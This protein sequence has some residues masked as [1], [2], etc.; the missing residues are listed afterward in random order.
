MLFGPGGVLWLLRH[1]LRLSW[2]G[3]WSATKSRGY[4]R[5][6]LYISLAAFLGFGGYWIARVLSYV[7][8]TPSPL[9]LGILGGVF[10]ILLTLMVSQALMLITEALYTRGDLDLLLASPLPP[11][12]VLIV[13]MAAI[14]LNVATLYLILLFA[15]FIWL[16]FFNGWRWMAFAPSVLALAL[17]ATAVGLAIAR[18]LFI[19]IGARATRVTA[20]VLAALI[21]AA[22]FLGSQVPNFSGGR[23][24][25][26]IIY[27]AVLD[28]L[29][30]IFGDRGSVLSLPGRSALGDPIA[31]LLWLGGAFAIYVIAVW[32]FSRRFA[33]SAA[34]IAA[35]GSRKRRDQ[36]TYGTQGGVTQSLLRK[37]WRLLLRDPFLLSQV[38][39]QLVYLLPLFFVFYRGF[40]DEGFDRRAIA[41]FSGAFVLLSSTL[42]ASLVW[43][44]VSAEDA[45]D[46][47]AAAP[48]S[49]NQ[50]DRAKALAAGI[51]V[52]ALMLFP[53]AG[54]ATISLSAA[55]WLAV[56]VGAAIVSAC[57]VGIWHQVPGNRKNFR[58]RSR[59]S[60]GSNLGQAFV[61][62]AWSG[63]TG[64]AIVGFELAAIIPAI[65]A[66][67]LLAAL[68]E[69]KPPPAK[70]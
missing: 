11:W 2:R 51:P 67:G 33:S 57:L 61:I 49:R 16:P 40:A 37:E 26:T 25:R 31:A 15:V 68:H 60:L 17:F 41:M 34:S 70:A 43:L 14:A 64:L 24:N 69:S 55:F 50:I 59:G 3:W 6:I 45:P 54:A 1:E 32:W 36:R 9:V 63:A 13:R 53:V 8:P 66:L 56:G 30:P 38:L 28:T 23:G 44:T 22:F 7:T 62:F 5:V 39:L 18:V 47:I 10:C 12:R 29:I 42:A 35:M 46:L 52:G 4:G 65:I 20:Q 48:V 19:L 27:R 21:G 58:R